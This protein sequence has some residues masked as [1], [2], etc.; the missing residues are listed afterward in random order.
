MSAQ[1]PQKVLAAYGN[2]IRNETI[3]EKENED[4]EGDVKKVKLNVPVA[5]V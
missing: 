5:P 2:N 1:K 3:V 4:S